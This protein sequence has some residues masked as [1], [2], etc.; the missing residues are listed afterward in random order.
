MVTKFVPNYAFVV[1]H[2]TDYKPKLVCL[3]QTDPYRFRDEELF[4]SFVKRLRILMLYQMNFVR[5]VI[6]SY[7]WIVTAF[8]QRVLICSLCYSAL[9]KSCP[10]STAEQDCKNIVSSEMGVFV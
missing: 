10:N 3:E 1:M 6:S 2:E 8:R 7:V 4:V 9:H 5:T